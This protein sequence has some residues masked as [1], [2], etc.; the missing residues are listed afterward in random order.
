LLVGIAEVM[1]RPIDIAQRL[2]NNLLEE[3][4]VVRDGDELRLP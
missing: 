1:D 3:G 2:V 4:L